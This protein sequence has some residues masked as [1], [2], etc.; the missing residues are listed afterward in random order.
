MFRLRSSKIAVALLASWMVASAGPGYAKRFLPDDPLREDLDRLPIQKPGEVELSTL[1]DVYEH[2]FKHRPD[3][4]IPRALNANTLGEVPNSSWFTNRIGVRD[5]SIEEIVRGADTTGG[6]DVSQPL[7]IVAGK[8]GGITPGFTIRDARGDIYFVK[9]DPKKHPNLSTAPDVIV[10]KFFYMFGYNVPENY[11]AYLPPD[12]L[13]IGPKAR[14]KVQ[15]KKVPMGPEYLDE[16]FS[17]AAGREDGTIRVVASRGLQGEP[18]G[19]FKFHGT[20]GDDPN[21][22]IPHEHRRELRGYR[23]FCAWLNHDDSRSVNSLDMYVSQGDR[24]YVLHHL[25]DFSSTL[26]SGSNAARQIAPQSPRAGNEYIFELMP[27]VK[28]ALTLGLWE[29]PWRKV[30]YEYPAYAELGRIE[31]KQF[32]PHRWKPEYPNPAFERMLLD[33]AFWATKIVARVSDE[34]IRALV[35]QGQYESREAE[36]H[37]ATMLIER[38]DKIVRYYFSQLNPLDGFA[39]EGDELVFHNLGETAGVGTASSYTYEWF[40]FDNEA[41]TSTP[42]GVKGTTRQTRLSL[43]SADEW[44]HVR[45]RTESVQLPLWNKSVDVYVRM[46]DRTVVGIDREL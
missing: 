34:A 5:M 29:R 13:R 16:V 44:L 23:V 24:G 45:L 43:P 15:N 46:R 42:L 12:Q 7:T 22:V 40:R 21:D 8:S 14:V 31:S 1:Y 4:E 20:R 39:V 26:G 38:R 3:G 2:T 28:T 36:Q 6:P 17:K 32:Q 33:D 11:I 19:P 37:L 27:L 35:L 10:S 25:I 18:V 41:E 9:F 30:K